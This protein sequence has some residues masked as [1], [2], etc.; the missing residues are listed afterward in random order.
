MPDPAAPPPPMG[1]PRAHRREVLALAVPA[2]ATLVAEPLLLLADTAIVGHLGT[3]ELAGL[4]IAGSLMGLLTGL[5]VF[6]AYATTATVARRLGAGDHRG[7]LAGGIDGMAL[8][9]LIGAALTLALQLGLD[10]VVG[11]YGAPPAVALQAVA[12]L[13]VVT[14]AFPFLLI[15]LAATGVLRGLQ[16]T[17]TP[18]VVVVALNLTNVALT[19]TFVHGFGFGIRGAAWG[20]LLA[21]SAASLLLAGVVVRGA[22]R[23]GVPLQ[24]RGAGVLRAARSGGWLV[25]RTLALQASVTVTTVI[26]TR[27][28]T[29]TLAAH[30][31]VNSLWVF[32]AFALDAIAIAA[33]AIIGRWLGA[34]DAS[35]VRVLTAMMV[36]WGVGFGVLLGL[37]LAAASPWL[38]VLFSPDPTVVA[39]VARTALVLAALLPLAGLVYVLDGVLIGA[40]DTRY[41]ALAGLAVTVVYVP[42]A[43]A[44]DAAGAGLVWLWVAYGVSMLGRG[45]ALGVRARGVAWQ[46]LGV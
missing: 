20:T 14:F 12:Y 43:L 5:C 6:L 23:S 44:V 4:G 29:T 26:A 10:A 28:G 19:L 42:L 7:A 18:L 38:G 41:L 8:A 33:Q 36:R 15:M 32:L 21:Q 37:A 39:L 31:V 22:R 40:G 13:R 46:R 35:A 25:V 16:D 24:V 27:M 9:A 30:Q 17:R 11:L 45:V 2:F 3:A 1:T 34:G